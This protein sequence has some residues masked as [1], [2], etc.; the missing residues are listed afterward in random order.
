MLPNHS[1]RISIFI[2]PKEHF[3]YRL[4]FIYKQ[5]SRAGNPQHLDFPLSHTQKWLT[6][7]SGAAQLQS[8]LDC[9]SYSATAAT[10]ADQGHLPSRAGPPIQLTRSNPIIRPRTKRR[11]R[12]WCIWQWVKIRWRIGKRIYLGFWKLYLKARRLLC[13]TFTDLPRLLIWVCALLKFCFFFINPLPLG[14]PFYE[15]D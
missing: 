9:T 8:P 1:H 4:T 12:K 7:I 10:A 2:N 13:C 11:R 5:K 15:L 14:K 3:S 6:W